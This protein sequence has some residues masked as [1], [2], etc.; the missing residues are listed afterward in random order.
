MA[1]QCLTHIQDEALGVDKS[2]SRLTVTSFQNMS[3]CHMNLGELTEFLQAS[4]F[5]FTHIKWSW[6]SQGYC[7]EEREAITHGDLSKES[8]HSKWGS[9]GVEEKEQ[10]EEEE[11]QEDGDA[12]NLP[13][14]RV[15]NPKLCVELNRW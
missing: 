3:L 6:W 8:S 1:S 2:L 14:D 7:E 9:E 5:F 4:F 10:E 15:K 11:G 13:K 12:L